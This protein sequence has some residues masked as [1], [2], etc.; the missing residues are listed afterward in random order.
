MLNCAPCV[1]A[2]QRGLRAN[3]LAYQR[4]LRANVLTCQ[5][6]LHAYVPKAC[7]VL[8]FTCQHANE[9]AN[10]PNGVPTFQIGVSTC[11]RT[12]QFFKHL[13]YE[14]LGEISILHF[15]IKDSILCLTSHLY[16]CVYVSHIKI[17]YTSFLYFIPS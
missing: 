14:M 1:P 13:S 4:G 8:I 10:V 7:H 12:C 5:R 15:C 2:C 9:R 6:G 16:I 17:Y 11:Q 3:V